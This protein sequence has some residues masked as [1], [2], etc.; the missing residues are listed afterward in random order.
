[1]NLSVRKRE[2]RL[3]A[4]LCLPLLSPLFGFTTAAIAV[5]AIAAAATLARSSPSLA[6]SL[7]P[8][9]FTKWGSFLASFLVS[10]ESGRRSDGRTSR[11]TL[12]ARPLVLRRGCVLHVE[13]ATKRRI[14]FRPTLGLTLSPTHR[15][16]YVHDDRSLHSRRFSSSPQLR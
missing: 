12:R 10:T 2:T 13:R 11:A 5:A 14:P 15:E 7:S 16:C 8:S 6:R 4:V 1:M 3:A 9:V